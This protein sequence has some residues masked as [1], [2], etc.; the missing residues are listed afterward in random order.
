MSRSE[1]ACS[2]AGKRSASHALTH[3]RLAGYTIRSPMDVGVLDYAL[4]PSLIAQEPLPKR[5]ESR[6]LVVERQAGSRTDTSV[7]ALGTWLR[8]GDVLVVNDA[9]VISARLH[10]T[11]PT[12]GAIEVLLIEPI[13]GATWKCMARGAGRVPTGESIDFG[14]GITG[15]WGDR[16]EP[17]F[18][19]IR[20][21]CDG[22]DDVAAALRQIGELP[23]PPYIRRPDGPSTLDRE[24][25]QTMFART[26]GAIAAPTAGLHFTPRLVAELT[27][28][29]IACVPL[30]LIV[31]PATFLPIRSTSLTDHNVPAERYVVPEETA[32][33]LN[34]TRAAGGRIVA[35]GTTSVRV[36]ET[37]ADSAGRVCGGGGR[38]DLVIS[39]GHRFRCV[40]ALFTNFHLPRSSLLSLVAAFAGIETTL[41]AYRAATASGYRFYSYG[42]AMLIV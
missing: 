6:M 41:E 31:G 20:L 5:D 7:R 25:Y 35:V 9:E 36:L 40:D 39:P 42:D 15:T 29:G 19:T 4:D 33:I 11:R 30:T 38:T 10:G 28:R 8:S 18:R 24:R 22:Y 1:S 26:P 2:P 3:S 37:V 13:E 14:H 21:Q 34:E 23:L 32:R 12:G 17:A 27:A 16:L